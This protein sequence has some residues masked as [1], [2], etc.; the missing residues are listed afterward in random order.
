MISSVVFDGVTVALGLLGIVVLATGAVR[1]Y[2]VYAI[3][4]PLDGKEMSVGCLSHG[5]PV[6]PP[7]SAEPP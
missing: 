3:Y 4:S 5:V 7:I 6:G 1:L 2:V